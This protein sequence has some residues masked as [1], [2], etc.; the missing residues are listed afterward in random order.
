[1]AAE[2]GIVDRIIVALGNEAPAVHAVEAAAVL[3]K[4]LATPLA[5]LLAENEQLL[6]LAE[7]PIALEMGYPSARV[8]PVVRSEIERGLRLR[9]ERARRL[10]AEVAERLA[11]EWS[12]EI[13]R[14]DVLREA[15]RR[16]APA[17]LIVVSRGARYGEEYAQTR[18]RH[19]HAASALR[20]RPVALLSGPGAAG[21]RALRAAHALA[22]EV[23]GE[24]LTLVAVPDG[25]TVRRLR[26]EH[27]RVLGPR[28]APRVRYLH[29]R[30]VGS[31][32]LGRLLRA[33][34]AGILIAS[35]DSADETLVD[36][37]AELACPVG[38]AT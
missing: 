32:A 23:G 10:L 4:G 8:R 24:V 21:I 15:L 28:R 9:A 13:V 35:R 36:Y 14:G 33:E 19:A 1:M 34:R 22:R 31:S 6:R 5:A 16:A 38:I 29:V 37:Y 20:S 2:E 3:A 17:E 27:E 12:L 7:L 30:D 26:L 25:E 18:A 11:L